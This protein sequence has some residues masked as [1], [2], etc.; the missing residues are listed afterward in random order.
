MSDVTKIGEEQLD[1]ALTEHLN[2]ITG[3][4]SAAIGNRTGVKMIEW[5]VPGFI[6]PYNSH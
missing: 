5:T 2:Q 4:V 6:I 1:V 3:Y